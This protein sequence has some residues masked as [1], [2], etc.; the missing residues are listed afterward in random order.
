MDNN[1]P[2]M[3]KQSS[4]FIPFLASVVVLVLNACGAG[5]PE[6]ITVD[7]AFSEYIAAYSSGMVTRKASIRIKLQEILPENAILSLKKDANG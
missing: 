7:P 6:V 1:N 4:I 5:K 3:K 2:I